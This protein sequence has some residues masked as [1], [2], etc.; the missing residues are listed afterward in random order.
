MIEVNKN[1]L[2]S[3][4]PALGKLI[5]RTSPMTLFKS[6]KIEAAD[7]KLRLA[8]C[9]A[10]EEISFELESESEDV[11]CCMVGFDE[12]R[13][14][15]R[16][17]RNKT[18]GLTYEAGTLLVGDRYLMT[19][20]DVEW[21]DYS[22]KV[23][24]PNCLLPDGVVEMFARAAQIVDRN[25]PR[26][27]LRGIN[28][29]AGGITVTNGKELLNYDC[30][31]DLGDSITIPLPLALMQSKAPHAGQL[32]YWPMENGTWF[33]SIVGPW[34]WTG[35]ALQGIYPNWKQVIPESNALT[36]SITFPPESTRELETFLK[37]V[38]D[39]PQR[40][41]VELS[42][43]T[44]MTLNVSASGEKNC[45]TAELSG[46]WTES[47]A[48]SK[49]VL[50]RLLREGHTR[51]QC[52]DRHVPILA[53][54]GSGRYIAMPM[55]QPR[56]EPQETIQNQPIKEE[57]QMEN[58]EM[59]VVPAPVQAVAPKQEPETAPNPLDD[60]S[61]SI[62]AFKLKLKA[63]F[64]EVTALARKVKEVQIAQK[65][66]ERDFIQAKRAIERIRMVSGF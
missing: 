35:K 33:S 49:T 59:K 58:T 27:I 10:S 52:G 41:A 32:F 66:K 55:F 2:A 57:T 11:F 51:I 47:L 7:G 3:A 28:L 42:D 30:P 50:L 15:I 6:I 48:L 38:P 43:G 17:G 44:G 63:S 21:P 29:S 46:D 14:A 37:N 53:L 13:D 16:S 9:G 39:D 4:L 40:N 8:T 22:P 24:A 54:G 60:L 64:E 25:E 5:C 31:L 1:P 62:E 20:K 18:V 65:Q 26:A 19:V 12:L 34:C 56:P 36:R 61:A 45:V 23:E